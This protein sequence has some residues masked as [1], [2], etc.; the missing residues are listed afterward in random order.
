MNSNGA[1]SMLHYPAAPT[2]SADTGDAAPDADDAFLP[3]YLARIGYS[4]AVAPTWD[5]L[6][7]LQ[8]GHIAAIP[9]EASDAL[10]GAGIHIGA[11]AIDATLIGQR[12]GGY[13]FEQNGLLLRAV[14]AAGFG[15]EGRIGRVTW[16]RHG[17]ANGRG[18]V[19]G[20]GWI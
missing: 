11:A 20:D 7:A 10:T 12:R 1:L 9:F 2:E 15:A 3:R 4:G 14:R 19:G 5:V 18:R 13:F 8:A 16:S 6:A 17:E